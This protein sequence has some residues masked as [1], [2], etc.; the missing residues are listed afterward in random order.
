MPSVPAAEFHG[1]AINRLTRDWIFGALSADNEVRNNMYLLRG[2]CRELANNNA[3]TAR[4]LGL[5]ASNVFGA[6]GV[7]LQMRSPSRELNVETERTWRQ[8]GRV[9]T[10]DGRLSWVDVQQL[11]DRTR[12]VDGECFLRKIPNADNE[13]G[14]A[15]QFLDADQLDENF[16]RPRMGNQNEIRMGVEVDIKNRPVA[17]HF[18]TTQRG[19]LHHVSYD[20]VPIPA[21]QIIHYYKQYRPNQTRGLPDLTPVM[22]DL[23]MLRGYTEAE[24]VAAR[25][26]AAKSG[27]FESAADE[28][29][30]VNPTGETKPLVMNAEPGMLEQLPAG[31]HFEAWDPTHPTTA[32]ADFVRS[33]LQA[34]ASGLNVS[35]AS[36]T[37]DLKQANFASSRVGLLSERDMWRVDQTF[38]IDNLCRPVFD[39]WVPNAWVFGQLST[40]LMPSGYMASATWQPR[41]WTWVDPLKDVQA[42]VMAKNNRLTDTQTIVGQ[43]GYDMVDIY[44]NHAREQA[45]AVENGVPLVG[46]ATADAPIDDNDEDEDMEAT[47]GLTIV[48]AQHG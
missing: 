11:A 35:Y 43:Q 37:S 23:N 1:A 39:G 5:S 31:V 2:R 46:G 45:V 15:L 22:Y 12:R 48:G 34:I 32:F 28:G 42:A 26:A 16:N 14:F 8:W 24:M 6:N 27:F 47:H 29:A 3:W 38:A 41:G 36:L 21:E 10:D 25:V 4:Y 40:A 7:I 17:Y 30:P 20:R 33:N 18:W 19:D 44:E 13:Y 9:A